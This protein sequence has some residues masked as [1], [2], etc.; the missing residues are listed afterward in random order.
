MIELC[1]EREREGERDVHVSLCRYEYVID[2]CELYVFVSAICEY[3]CVY[4]HT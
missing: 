1:R 3:V 4:K 2:T